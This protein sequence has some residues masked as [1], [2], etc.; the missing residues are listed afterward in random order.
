MHD[1]TI[2]LCGVKIGISALCPDTRSFF[3]DYLSSGPAELFVAILPEDL[4]YERE[5][6]RLQD[7]L[8]GVPPRRYSDRYMETQA[9]LRKVADALLMK[10]KLLFHGSCLAVGGRAYMFTAPSG[11]GK[12]THTRLWLELLPEAHVLNGDKPFLALEP[13]GQV[14]CCADP[15]QGKENYGTNEILP[16][17]A[18]CIIHRGESNRIE[19]IGFSEAFA[20]LIRQAYR[21][22]GGDGML[23]TL[24]L[25]GRIGQ[26]VKLYRLWCNMDLEAAKVSSAAMLKR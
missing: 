26:G 8:D 6:A 16:L 13:D 3:R 2:E 12:T 1:F 21:P 25:V 15:W 4:S 24:P 19:E 11:T 22:E 18:I 9:I 17:Q 10:D 20:D 14:L 7:E 5:Q 23:K